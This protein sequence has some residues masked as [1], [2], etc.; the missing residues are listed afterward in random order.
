MIQ[1]LAAL[2]RITGAMQGISS[3]LQGVAGALNEIVKLGVYGLGGVTLKLSEKIF[4]GIEN[5]P[6]F[7]KF[8]ATFGSKYMTPFGTTLY[9]NEIQQQ[10]RQAN[11][12]LGIAGQLG[13]TIEKN[14]IK[15]G[16]A[17]LEFGFSEKEIVETYKN[18]IDEYQRNEIFSEDDLVRIAK[19]NYAFGESFNKLFAINRLYGGS[20]ETTYEFLEDLNKTVDRFGLNS[21]KVFSDI[22]T[23]IRLID[24]YNFKNGQQGLANMVIQANKLGMQMEEIAG[25]AEKVYNP[26]DAIDAAAGLQ[27]LGG[28]FAM[29]GD[30]FQLL[31]EANNDLE[32]FTKR[33]S[34][35]TKG[36]ATLNKTTGQFE[37][38]SLN[39]RQLREF[40]KITG[41]SIESLSQ[42]AKLFAKEDLISKILPKDL[43][44]YGN[45]DEFISKIASMSTFMGGTPKIKIDGVEKLV[46]ELS[47]SDFDKISQISVTPEGDSFDGLVKSNQ[48]LGDQIAIFSN[49]F[50]RA[51]NKFEFIAYEID[52]LNKILITGN[53]SLRN[54]NLNNVANVMNEAKKGAAQ[55]FERVMLPTLENNFGQAL[56][57]AW[58]NMDF[59]STTNQGTSRALVDMMGGENSTGGKIFTNFIDLE[60]AIHKGFS[61]FGGYVATFGGW[62]G[63][64]TGIF[65]GDERTTYNL[66][67]K[68]AAPNQSGVPI[69]QR[70]VGI[71]GQSMIPVGYKT[72]F[73]ETD[74]A[75]DLFTQNNDARIKMERELINVSK[76]E[77]LI[78]GANATQ[79]IEFSYN[80]EIFDVYDLFENP[81]FKEM[82]RKDM[83]DA[84]ANTLLSYY[85][86][87]GRN[88][89]PSD[90]LPR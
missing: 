86:N 28:Q 82:L 74:R 39:F 47:K 83:G 26:E 53:E 11:R 8:D 84:Q 13:Q 68:S 65:G 2:G 33:L 34:Q 43:S 64:L 12:Q 25:F 40:A 14:I 9:W 76:S 80:G 29:L 56:S 22:Q 85:T 58:Q 77:V 67:Y 78:K 30:P 21:K 23:N 37:L 4:S 49:Q 61:E 3:T 88:T 35:V 31:Y 75:L 42:Q 57:N 17:S 10:I 16:T 6:F 20:I 5:T 32:A 69:S 18:F 27:M 36:M 72:S 44:N 38:T 19:V 71:M 45:I 60:S 50:T 87:G 54:G 1:I 46:S 52:V 55:S 90:T 73:S 79:K 89:A 66:S 51:I 59:K 81:K 63:K 7:K 62:V 70:K 15:S 24:K 41:Q 48:T